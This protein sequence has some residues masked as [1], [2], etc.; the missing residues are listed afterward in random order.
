LADGKLLWKVPF[1]VRYNACTPMVDGDTVL[2][3]GTGG[4]TKAIKIEKDGD[5]FTT[6][7]LWSNSKSVIYNTPIIRDGLV[8][9]LTEANLL[10]CV[11]AKDGKGGWETRMM[12]GGGGGGGKKGGGMGGY[13]SI[14]DVGPVLMALTPAGR[15]V[16][17]EPNDKD[18]KEVAG[19]KVA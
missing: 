12:G 11:S 8:F 14:V 6:K 10:Y 18:F 5:K 4:G 17:F 13:G 9:G 3:S 19:Y 1:S 16:V 15:L 2:Y 7:E